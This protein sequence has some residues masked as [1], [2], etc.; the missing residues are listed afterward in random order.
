LRRYRPSNIAMIGAGPSVAE[1]AARRLS[2]STDTLVFDG[3][4]GLEELRSS[5]YRKIAA[6]ENPLVLLG[7]GAPL[8]EEVA[9]DIASCVGKATIVTVGGWFDQ[10]AQKGYQYFPPMV[11]SLRLGWLVRVVREPRRLARRYTHD[12][13]TFLIQYPKY[14][15]AM[16]GLKPS[17]QPTE[18]HA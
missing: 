12:V 13:A 15:A 9:Q 11:H 6:L 10:L 5:R 1:E 7:L 2:L 16:V 18:A 17:M 4:S 8:Q 3:Y 14:R